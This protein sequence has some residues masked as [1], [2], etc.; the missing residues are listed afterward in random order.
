MLQVLE[1][2]LKLSVFYVVIVL[3]IEVQVYSLNVDHLVVFK[4]IVLAYF[5]GL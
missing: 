5:A 1:E 4:F 2:F 3:T